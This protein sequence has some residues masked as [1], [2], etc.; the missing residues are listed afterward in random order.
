LDDELFF[1]HDADVWSP[2]DVVVDANRSGMWAELTDEQHAL[3]VRIRELAERE[4]RPW[5]AHWDETETFPQRS[6]ELLAA[7]GVLGECVPEEYGGRGRGIL[8]GCIIVEELARACLSSAMIAQAFLNGP[9]RAIHVLGTEEQRQ[10]YLPG[11]ADGT[12]HFAIA[13][14]E[15]GAGSAGT[16][17]RTELRPHNGGYR[18]HGVKTWVTG[19]RE[20]TTILVFCRL[21]GTSGPYGIGAVIVEKGAPGMA[22]PEVEPKM[23]M[24]GVAEATLRFDGVPIDPDE[25]LIRPD[26]SSKEGA[27]ILV[28]QFNP[29][30][31]GNAAMCTGIA[32]AALDDTVAHLNRRSQFGRALAEFQGLQWLVADMALDVEI[33][34]M[35]VWRAARTA[36][37]GFPAQRETVMAKL[38]S[39]EMVQRVT[40]AAIQAHGARGYSRRWPLERYFRDARGL[41]IGGGTSQIMR[42]L[43]GGIVLGRRVSQR[44]NASS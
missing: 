2:V 14:S 19:G 15:P 34:R 12:R 3:R 17:L 21:P 11:V 9:W 36:G 4:L 20:A 28:N 1:D 42:N 5:A 24:R 10:R 7:E 25:V 8:E 30:R 18:L 40:N 16:D 35:L 29:E 13:M 31:C 43:L 44:G 23:G 37:D 41:T 32:Q 27:R 26:A 39:S 33:S 22:P 38:H 6:L